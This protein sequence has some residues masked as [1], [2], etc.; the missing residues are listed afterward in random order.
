MR[1]FSLLKKTEIPIPSIET[2]EK[3]VKILDNITEYVTELQ[4]E[5]QARVKQ[6]E[7]YRDQ[8]LSREYLC[9]TS[10]KIFN[11]Y[12]NSFEKIKL[13]DIATITRGRRLVRSDLEE[14]GRFPVFQNSLKPLGYYHMNNFSGDKTCLISAGAAGDIFYAEEDFWAADDVFV[15]DSSS[16][17]NKYI[18]Y[19][20]LNKQNM[21]K[22]KVR[23]ASIPRIS[24]DEIKK[25]EI[26]VPTIELQKK[27]VEILDKFQSLVSE[28]K[29]LLPQEIEQR[30]K[31]YEFYRE[32]LF[33]FDD[34]VVNTHTHTQLISSSYFDILREAC[35][36]AGIKMG[37]LKKLYLKDITTYS[38]NKINITELNETNYVGVDNLLKNKLGKVDS[39]NVPTSGSFNLFREGDILIGNIRPYLRK[40]WISDIEGGASPDVLVIRKKDSF[41]NNLLSKYL[42]QV[43]SSEQF[44][45]YDIKHS[46][47]AKMP[48]G[49]KAK[50]MDFEILV[51][52]L[53]VQEYVVSILDK[54][55]SLINDINEGLPKEIELRQ[56]QYEYYREKL[57]DFPR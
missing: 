25:I 31:Q 1:H 18:Y 6:Y 20:L 12:N 43:L 40:I 2:Q 33:N 13:K 23:K 7:Y 8:I 42:Y 15:I 37:Q 4:V 26:L 56:K 45:D 48:R 50:I 27:I 19:Y 32:K 5:L 53:Y 41:N 49:N 16:V 17:V 24:R 11:N 57:L 51:P 29:G 46:K 9:K 35:D 21:I 54:F 36:I 52:P 47:G 3:I 10:E 44:F 38:N 34:K 28:T 30:Q 55:D 39:K 22:S 14:K